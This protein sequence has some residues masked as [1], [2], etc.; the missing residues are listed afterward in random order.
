[1]KAARNAKGLYQ[2][3]IDSYFRIQEYCATY[4]LYDYSDKYVWIECE[5]CRKCL[6][7]D[8]KK[9]VGISFTD[10][11]DCLLYFHKKYLNN[12]LYA[13]KPEVFDLTM[14]DEKL[15]IFWVNIVCRLAILLKFH[16][17][18]L[19]KMVK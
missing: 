4:K 14:N 2:N 18:E 13:H 7:P 10:F 15:Y 16:H 6:V 11:R 3:K 5:F 17:M 19:I 9:L 12:F 8:F 1:M